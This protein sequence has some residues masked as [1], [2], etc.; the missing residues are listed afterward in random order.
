VRLIIGLVAHSTAAHSPM[1]VTAR[2]KANQREGATL[3]RKAFVMSVNPG[4]ED[5]YKRRHDALWPELRVALQSHGVIS[6]SIFLLS[7][8]QQ[9]FA[10]AEFEDEQRWAALGA[11][12]VCRRW[13]DH[14]APLMAH[15]EDRSPSTRALRE[16]FHLL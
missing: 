9:L 15:N 2:L 1:F 10:Y 12:E 11:T 13:W 7:E 3:I 4:A 6:Y 8:T 14:M 5:E 16:M